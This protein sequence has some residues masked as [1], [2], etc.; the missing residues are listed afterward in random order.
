M[1]IKN[2]CI[3]GSEEKV[4]LRDLSLLQSDL[5]RADL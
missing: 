4:P 1:L 2:E 5:G 3:G